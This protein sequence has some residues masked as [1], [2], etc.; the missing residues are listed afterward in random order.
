VVTFVVGEFHWQART[1]E[2]ASMEDFI[3]PPFM[4]SMEKNR[5]EITTSLSEYI[6]FNE[7]VQAFKDVPGISLSVPW[8]ASANKP[9]PYHKSFSTI[10]NIWGLSLAAIVLACMFFSM[11]KEEK[12]INAFELNDSDFSNAQKEFISR[13]FDLTDAY[14]NIQL[15]LNNQWLSTN[16]TLVNETTGEEYTGETGVEYYS[17]Y[18]SDGSWAEG[19]Q[20]SEQLLSGIP[21][22]KY[23]AEISAESDM[24]SKNLRLK[25]K[26]NGSMWINFW[27]ALFGVSIYPL[28]VLW[29]RHDFEKSRWDNSDFSPYAA[30]ESYSNVLSNLVDESD[31]YD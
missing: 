18:D 29:R 5:S 12:L 14:G 22:G 15:A 4:C 26:R 17:G 8:K 11:S 10:M 24:P 21:G 19:S 6:D 23:H 1:G 31:D 2:K 9:N 7:I 3:N 30:N 13:A 20:Y 25:I 16:V 27:L 28:W